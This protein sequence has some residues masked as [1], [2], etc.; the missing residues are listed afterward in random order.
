MHRIAQKK[1]R[2]DVAVQV[3]DEVADEL[4]Q[5]WRQMHLPRRV[6]FQLRRRG[7]VLQARQPQHAVQILDGAAIEGEETLAGRFVWDCDA[8]RTAERVVREIRL[9]ARRVEGGA[10]QH[11]A[12]RGA[13]PQQRTQQSQRQVVFYAPLVHLVNYHRLEAV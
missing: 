7:V 9:V 2:T 5:R 13:A 4:V 3:Q 12:Q 11:A 6:A 1:A 10:H 8:R